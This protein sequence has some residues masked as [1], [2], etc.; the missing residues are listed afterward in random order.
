MAD[1]GV[2]S[3]APKATAPSEPHPN[4]EPL[5]ARNSPGQAHPRRAGRPPYLRTHAPLPFKEAASVYL[6]ISHCAG[7]PK[8]TTP[9]SVN[10]LAFN[11]FANLGVT[12][13]RVRVTVEESRRRGGLYQI[14]IDQSNAA[15]R[16]H[17]VGLMRDVYEGAGRIIVWLGGE[18]SEGLGILFPDYQYW[19][20]EN[21]VNTVKDDIEAQ[22][23][24]T[25]LEGS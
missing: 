4:T 20:I 21:L 19:N 11:T 6:A 3:G 24:P 16:A 23:N 12:L 25:T 9:I 10:R 17:Q 15:E 7:D 18:G 2:A 8:V 14:C 1:R 22:D 13:R 5:A